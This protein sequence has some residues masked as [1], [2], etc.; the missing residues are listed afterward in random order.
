VMFAKRFQELGQ[1]PP[2]G[3]VD[4]EWLADNP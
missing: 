4:L 2:P 1:V 3:Y